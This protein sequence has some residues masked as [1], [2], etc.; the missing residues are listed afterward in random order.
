MHLSVENLVFHK[1]LSNSNASR[2]FLLTLLL[3]LAPTTKELENIRPSIENVSSSEESNRQPQATSMTSQNNPPQ[4]Q[5]K[6]AMFKNAMVTK[7]S[8]KLG[9]GELCCGN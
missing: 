1:F 9:M 5:S 6:R 3:F 7:I 4:Q 2:Y 8:E